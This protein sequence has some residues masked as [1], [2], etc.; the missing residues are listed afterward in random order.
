MGRLVSM[1]VM[2]DGDIRRALM[3]SLTQEH[4][5]ELSVRVWPEMSV[6]L[7]AS[8]VDVGLINGAVAGYEIKSEHDNLGR[9]PSQ[10]VHY[11]R[12]LDFATVVVGRR[13]V[14]AVRNIVP[15]WWGITV[16][17]PVDGEIQFVRQRRARPNPSI[18]PFYIAQLLWRDEALAVL[19]SREAHHGLAKAT[20]WQMWDALATLP[21]EQ[22]R[23]DVRKALTVRPP[24]SYA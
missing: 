22:L 23:A 21:L 2:R 13:H 10:V 7:G 19:R 4:I 17:K 3:A 14:R 24:S 18:D 16:A 9:L 5:G 20:R 12:C 11:S 8:R 1:G 15:F 6:G